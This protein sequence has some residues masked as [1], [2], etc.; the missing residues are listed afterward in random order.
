M[1]VESSSYCCIVSQ[2]VAFA[3]GVRKKWLHPL[4]AA[5]ASCYFELVFHF[6]Y[7]VFHKQAPFKLTL[8]QHNSP[9][10][11]SGLAHSQTMLIA[12]VSISNVVSTWQMLSIGP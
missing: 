2:N 4:V 9:T 8:R 5:E 1:I 7:G 10:P 6:A 3:N 11:Y 12:F